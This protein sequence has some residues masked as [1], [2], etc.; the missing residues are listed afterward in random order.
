VRMADGLAE[1]IERSVA[2]VAAAAAT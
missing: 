2:E 1:A